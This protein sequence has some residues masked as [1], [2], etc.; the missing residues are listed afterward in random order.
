MPLNIHLSSKKV[1]L[2]GFHNAGWNEYSTYC[3]QQLHFRV[4]TTTL[5]IYKRED[6]IYGKAHGEEVL[7]QKSANK[8]KNPKSVESALLHLQKKLMA[9]T[10]PATRKAII[11]YVFSIYR[12]EQSEVDGYIT[13]IESEANPTNAMLGYVVERTMDADPDPAKNDGIDLTGYS[14]ARSLDAC[15]YLKDLFHGKDTTL[16]KEIEEWSGYVNINS[17]PIDIQ[18][19]LASSKKMVVDTLQRN[20]LLLQ[21]RKPLIPI[22]MVISAE[23]E[24]QVPVFTPNWKQVTAKI[25]FSLTNAEIRM[26][27]KLMHEINHP[28]INTVMDATVTFIHKKGE[29]FVQVPPPWLGHEQEWQKRTRSKD[30]VAHLA[31]PDEES[32][33]WIKELMA[34]AAETTKKMNEQSWKNAELFLATCN[35]RTLFNH[36]KEKS[37]SFSQDD[38]SIEYLSPNSA[39]EPTSKPAF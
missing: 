37:K 1:T 9:I 8:S 33:T 35:S 27:Y 36:S 10:E 19:T 30:K 32:Q 11:N 18:K 5:P 22:H 14:F 38:S 3:E 7:H 13:A 2:L 34:L 28:L 29:H 15:A 6:S 21:E 20:L 31:R 4:Y 23:N 24:Q 17:K 39:G 12:T 26:I 25:G 16:F